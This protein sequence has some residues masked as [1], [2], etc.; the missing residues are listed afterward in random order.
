MGMI[1]SWLHFVYQSQQQH[2]LKGLSILYEVRI[3]TKQH[4]ALQL[5]TFS[6]S[7]TKMQSII[8]IC[9]S[10]LYGFHIYDIVIIKQLLVILQT[11]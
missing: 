8:A 1:S 2:V 7:L 3:L 11:N 10:F 4:E 5:H 6:V 9:I